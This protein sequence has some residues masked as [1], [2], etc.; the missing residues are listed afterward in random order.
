[1]AG[2]ANGSKW[3]SVR[4]R[5]TP[6]PGPGAN[7]RSACSL[8]AQAPSGR[9][10]GDRKRSYG[11][12]P[13]GAPLPC[14]N[15]LLP[16]RRSCKAAAPICPSPDVMP[17]PRFLRA[18]D[19]DAHHQRWPALSPRR[20]RDPRRGARPRRARRDRLQL[21][22]GARAA[23]REPA[24]PRA[25]RARDRARAR[26]DPGGLP[27]GKPHH[28]AGR[29]RS[30]RAGAVLRLPVCGHHPGAGGAAG[31]ARRPRGLCRSARA[32]DEE[33]RR[34]RGDGAGC[35]GGLSA[36]CGKGVRGQDD[37]RRPRRLLRPAG[38]R[39]RRCARSARTIPAICSTRPAARAGR[40][41]S[42]CGSAR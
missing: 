23:G 30:R 4:I 15:G 39:R 35:A 20:L 3:M 22:L 40:S 38:Q 34:D 7:G 31:G 1:M 25:A 16:V 8:V 14:T 24:L 6:W 33:L 2:S 21:L 42:T 12:D 36:R 27:A 11:A 32:P 5:N 17:R 13:Q 9:P 28:A 29:H 19:P 37:D 10:H 26:P 41:A 18:H